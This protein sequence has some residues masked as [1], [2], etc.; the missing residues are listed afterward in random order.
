MIGF[1]L[2]NPFYLG[3]QSPFQDCQTLHSV[4]SSSH[5]AV[6]V[7]KLYRNSLVDSCANCWEEED[8]SGT[9]TGQSRKACA[10]CQ[11]YFY[12]SVKCQHHSVCKRLLDLERRP[13]HPAAAR[14]LNREHY[15][16]HRKESATLM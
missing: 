8:V 9:Y 6:E 16:L 10:R 15:K 12:C 4:M 14:T 13:N 5:L 3:P 1:W 7:S 2:L 11:V